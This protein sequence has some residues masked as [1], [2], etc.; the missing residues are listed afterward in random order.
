MQV[1]SNSLWHDSLLHS[2]K[3]TRPV[4]FS[5]L[6]SLKWMLVMRLLDNG[7]IHPV[8]LC[9]DLLDFLMWAS[10]PGSFAC[11][12]HPSFLNQVCFIS[13]CQTHQTTE[14]GLNGVWKFLFLSLYSSYFLSLRCSPSV[15]TPGWWFSNWP[16]QICVPW[17]SVTWEASHFGMCH[18]CFW[19]SGFLLGLANRRFWQESWECKWRDLGVL[20]GWFFLAVFL[21]LCPKPQLPYCNDPSFELQL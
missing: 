10:R 5:D 11:L 6:G 1:H 13:I 7:E 20:L 12:P 4:P 2:Q 18:L 15:S 21:V 8:L 19:P 9:Q 3:V 16:L 14:D 17:C